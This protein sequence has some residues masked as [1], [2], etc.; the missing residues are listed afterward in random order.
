MGDRQLRVDAD[1]PSESPRGIQEPSRGQRGGLGHEVHELHP[2][3]GAKGKV[4]RAYKIK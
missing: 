1:S 2:R 3:H 4:K